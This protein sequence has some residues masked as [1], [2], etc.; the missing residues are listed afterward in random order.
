MRLLEVPLVVS[1]LL[2]S[3]GCTSASREG[4]P[5]GSPFS[6]QAGQAAALIPQGVAVGD[7]SATSALVWVRTDGPAMV[8]VEYAPP[9]V[10]DQA[11]KSA[12]IVAP[13][14]LAIRSAPYK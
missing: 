1:M 14:A 2:V 10:W 8:Q 13:V 12:M 6:D 11:A 7:V 4:L 5:A 9:S 3:A